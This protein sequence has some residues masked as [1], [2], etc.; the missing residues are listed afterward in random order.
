MELFGAAVTMRERVFAREP[1][2]RATAG[3]KD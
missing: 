3:A 1:G 2:H